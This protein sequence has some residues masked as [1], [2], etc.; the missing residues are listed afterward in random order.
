MNRDLMGLLN[1]SNFSYLVDEFG[2][3]AHHSVRMAWT[4]AFNYACQKCGVEGGARYHDSKIKMLFTGKP[5]ISTDFANV[6][7]DEFCRWVNLIT[8]ELENKRDG[9]EVVA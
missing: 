8:E 4:A 6:F 5:V 9:M 2:E 1:P 3:D 7:E